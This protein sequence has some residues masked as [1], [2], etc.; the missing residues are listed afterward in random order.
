M[1]VAV[2][3]APY[4]LEEFPSPPL[5]IAYAAAAF[6][7]ARCGVPVFDYTI[8]QYSKEK[9]FSTFSYYYKDFKQKGIF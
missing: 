3:A 2:I 4:P 1:R 9:I 7:A 5:G 6:E 8:S